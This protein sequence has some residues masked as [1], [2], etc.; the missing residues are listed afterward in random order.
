M[1][2]S[3]F[4]QIK[5]AN[6]QALNRREKIKFKGHVIGK[7]LEDK[8]TGGLDEANDMSLCSYAKSFG[9]CSLLPGENDF[10]LA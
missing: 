8:M 2:G 3:I 10:S 7:S 4:K 9:T 6:V 1:F 5:A